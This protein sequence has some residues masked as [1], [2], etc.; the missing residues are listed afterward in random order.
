[1]PCIMI[2]VRVDILNVWFKTTN[3]AVHYDENTSYYI[4]YV[5]FE[6]GACICNVES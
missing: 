6:T 4:E 3:G 1:M 2:K 5:W